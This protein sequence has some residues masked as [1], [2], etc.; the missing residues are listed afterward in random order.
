MEVY[1]S[2]Y[3]TSDGGNRRG[4]TGSSRTVTLRQIRSTDIFSLS[5][6]VTRGED[7]CRYKSL[8][9]NLFCDQKRNYYGSV[10]TFTDMYPGQLMASDQL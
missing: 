4:L 1:L 8:E 3:T 10:Q 9:V 2:H 5:L 7:G 6:S